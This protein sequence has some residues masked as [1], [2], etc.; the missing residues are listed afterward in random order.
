M[1]KRR[2]RVL[3]STKVRRAIV[4][5]NRQDKNTDRLNQHR[6]APK[7]FSVC[8]NLIRNRRFYVSVRGIEQGERLMRN[9][10][11]LGV[12]SAS[13]VSYGLRLNGDR[14]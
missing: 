11:K 3:N 10:R 5:L 6:T 4:R 9:S 2:G 8:V 7:G 14:Y 1:R 12:A 13:I